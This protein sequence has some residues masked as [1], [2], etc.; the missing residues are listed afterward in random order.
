M[1]RCGRETEL[2]TLLLTTYGILVFQMD[3]TMHSLFL[4]NPDLEMNARRAEVVVGWT[5][6]MLRG[7]NC[8]VFEVVDRAQSSADWSHEQTH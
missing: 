5:Q 6:T 7:I 3:W 4:E 8:M 1:F 2:T